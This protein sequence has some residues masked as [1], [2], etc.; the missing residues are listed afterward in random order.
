MELPVECGRLLF[1]SVPTAADVSVN[2][3]FLERCR[4]GYQAGSRLRVDA[5]G[6]NGRVETLLART[7]A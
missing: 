3:S 2:A 7:L 5:A 4:N 6:I 1:K